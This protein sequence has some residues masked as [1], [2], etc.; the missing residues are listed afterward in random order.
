MTWRFSFMKRRRHQQQQ[1]HY[2]NRL[3][4]LYIMYLRRACALRVV[5][6]SKT[7]HRWKTDS[8]I[9]PLKYAVVGRETLNFFP[10]IY[11]LYYNNY[12]YKSSCV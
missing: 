4:Y 5:K 10:I 9:A 2:Y 11:I 6:P 3:V 12:G 8:H 1:Q 7:A